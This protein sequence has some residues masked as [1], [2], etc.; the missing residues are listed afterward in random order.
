MG[1]MYKWV[2]FLILLVIVVSGGM[3]VLTIWSGGKGLAVPP[4]K[5]MSVVEAVDEAQ[6][7]GLKLK[8]EQIESTLPGGTVLSQWPE[9]G[10]KIK[11]DA[12]VILKV[13]KGGNRIAL[14]DVR[15]LEYS[16]ALKKLE[17]S[18]FQAGDTLRV[19]DDTRAA[20]VVIAQSP[21]APVMLES[22]RKIDLLVSQGQVSQNGLI[23]VPE[24]LQRE[25]QIAR[26]LVEESGLVVANVEYVYTQNSPEG[27]VISIRP[28]VGT[29]LKRGQ[30]VV[31]QVASL[32][33]P[34]SQEKA[35]V[36][37]AGTVLASAVSGTAEKVSGQTEATSK[38]QL[39][40]G[41]TLI[42][43]KPPSSKPSTA[44]APV[45][46]PSTQLAATPKS[47]PVPAGSK[48]AK[49]RYQ[50][51]PLTKQMPL[52]IEIVDGSGTRVLLNREVKGG[53]YVSLEAPY[54]EEGVVTIFLGGEFVWQ[55]RYR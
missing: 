55:D 54:I 25:E 44:T 40:S 29:S 10:A 22:T 20:G 9:P 41:G 5:E 24:V 2:M 48:V 1:R 13:S 42:P 18:G 30:G 38:S 3:A 28:K 50:V 53:E 19:S 26:K 16:Q 35:E 11:K 17:E 47:A 49:I 8:I 43:V 36:S 32:K 37:Q 45:T 4:L 46:K 6:R 21:S 23:Q 15:G 12:T 27:M 14:P 39:P 34:P 52:K 33:K 7:L 51:P 31:L